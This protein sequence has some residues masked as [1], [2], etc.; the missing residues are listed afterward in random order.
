MSGLGAEREEDTE[1]EAGSRLRVVSTE[2]DTEIELT[3]LEIMTWAE[4]GHPTDWATHVPLTFLILKI[5]EPLN[6]FFQLMFKLS[7]MYLSF[8]VGDRSLC[9]IEY[10]LPHICVHLVSVNVGLFSRCNQIK[11]K[12][13][14]IKVDPKSNDWCPSKKRDTRYTYIG[15]VTDRLQYEWELGTA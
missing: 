11:I 8:W 12:S 14:W 4:V 2:P 13:Y 15:L 3:D 5:Y 7:L 1:S 9:W 6:V 10:C